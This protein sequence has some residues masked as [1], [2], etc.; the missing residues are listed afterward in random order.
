MEQHIL[1]HPFYPDRTIPLLLGN[2]VSAEDGT[3]A[4]HTAPGHGQ[5]DHQVFQQY[6]LLNRYS[7][8]ELNPVDARGVYLS[9]TPP[10][11][12]LTLAGL[13]IWKANPLIVDALRL[14][15]VLLAAAEMHHSYPHC[16]RHKTPIVFRATP[17]WFI[18]MEQ[19]A[20]RSA[21]LKAIT[22]VTWYPQWG[23]ARILSMIE[24]RPDWT[25]SRQRTWGVPIPLF[26]HR[27]SG[28]PHPRSAALMRQIADRVEQQGV[29]I[30][31]SLDQTELLGTEAD[32]YEK[33]PIS[34]T[35]GLIPASPMKQCSLS[36]AS[37][38]PLTSTSKVPTNT[39][40][41]SNPPSSPASPWTTPHPTNNA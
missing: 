32:Q 33:S 8:A 38:N 11:G 36:A 1:A 19:A 14:R 41:G 30:W 9:T 5:E 23:Q 22:H 26:V 13:H 6:G 4:V 39:A 21:A 28:A 40:A 2:H 12:E 31:Y 18:S 16:W 17:Q 7:A 29:D 25:I 15:G 24:N 35:S 10:L 3:G 34:L 37:L 27:H 20:L